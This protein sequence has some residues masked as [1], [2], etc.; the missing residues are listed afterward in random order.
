[1]CCNS[2]HLGS[3]NQFYSYSVVDY[4]VHLQNVTVKA[5]LS[6]FTLM[7]ASKCVGT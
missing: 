5:L 7:M 3:E 6:S 1:M 4:E 2:R